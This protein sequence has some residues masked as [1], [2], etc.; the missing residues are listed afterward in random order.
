MKEREEFNLKVYLQ[1]EGCFE[2]NTRPVL[3]AL[4]KHIQTKEKISE[5]EALSVTLDRAV[6]LTADTYMG[7][8][9]VDYIISKFVQ[10][11]KKEPP[12]NPS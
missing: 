5:D 8:E 2:R 12:R 6:M 3:D 9:A 11:K 1:D 10:N 7:Q 4:V